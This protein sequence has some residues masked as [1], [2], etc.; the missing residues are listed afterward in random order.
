MEGY[1][2]DEDEEQD[3]HVPHKREK[4]GHSSS[5]ELEFEVWIVANAISIRLL[6]YVLATAL[7]TLLVYLL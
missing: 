3:G 4:K 5:E 7:A 2:R 6:T 1:D